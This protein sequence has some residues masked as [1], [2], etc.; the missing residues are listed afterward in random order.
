MVKNFFAEVSHFNTF[1]KN[2]ARTQKYFSNI[3][4]EQKS[5]ATPDL[6]QQ[7]DPRYQLKKI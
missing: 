5:L 1:L 4:L 7:E 2:E 6:D 3:A